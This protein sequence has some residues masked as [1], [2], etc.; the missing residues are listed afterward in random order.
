MAKEIHHKI[1]GIIIKNKK[2]LMCRK[3]DEPHFIMPGGKVKGRET[4]KKTLERELRE[5]LSVQL[6]SMNFFKSYEAPHFRDENKIVRMDTYL[7]EVTGEPRATSEINEIRW[8]ESN[9]KHKGIKVASINEDYLIPELKKL[10][11][12]K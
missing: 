2:L 3:Y 5:E 6:K 8:I 11:L 10:K 9:Y 1:A 12:I 7:V 4:P